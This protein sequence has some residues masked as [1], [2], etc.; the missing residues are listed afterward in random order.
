M[1]CSLKDNYKNFQ[2]GTEDEIAF[3]FACKLQ[4]YNNMK[5]LYHKVEKYKEKF[6]YWEWFF[7]AGLFAL[8]NFF[9]LLSAF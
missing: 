4:D 9:Y 3:F 8:G 7:Y 6:Q 1:D 5:L 2:P